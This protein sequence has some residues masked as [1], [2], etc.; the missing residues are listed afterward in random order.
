[1]LGAL[2]CRNRRVCRGSH[3]D[4]GC[5]SATDP[6]SICFNTKL[7]DIRQA[8]VKTALV[9]ETV[10]GATDTRMACL[11]REGQTAIPANRGT[12]VIRGRPLTTHLVQAITLARGFIIKS[13][14]KLPGI[15]MRPSITLVVNA[16]AVKHQRPPLAI[17]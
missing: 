4:N 14:D 7:M 13:L 6:V 8:V 10:L 2:D 11:N 17:H 12:G 5:G 16:L 1:M 9:P 15:E 3:T